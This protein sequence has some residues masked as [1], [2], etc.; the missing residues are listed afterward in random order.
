MS[1]TVWIEDHHKVHIRWDRDEIAPFYVECPHEGK[2]AICTRDRDYCVV[3]RYMGIYGAELNV[4][5]ISLDD[6]PVEIAWYPI[7]GASDLD[8]VIGGLYVVPVNDVE[9]RASKLLKS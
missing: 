7:L 6:G 4:G 2:N 3:D 9:Y 8:Q 1:E 5:S